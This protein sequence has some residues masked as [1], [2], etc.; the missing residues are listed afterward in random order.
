MPAQ[1]PQPGLAPRRGALCLLDGVVQQGRLLS[2][3]LPGALDRLP[4]DERARALRLAT[5]TLR[6]MDRADRLLGP[7][8]SRRPPA[9]GLNALRLGVVEMF[10]EGA[11]AH[12]VVNSLVAIMREKAQTRHLSGLVNAVL[13]KAAG[14]PAEAWENL[15]PPRLPRWLRKPL[16]AD[17]GKDAVAAIE[18]AHARDAPLD[19]SVK[20]PADA[21]A[22]A[23][24]LG[25]QVLPTGTVRLAAGRQVSALAGFDAGAW[26]V[27]DAAAALPVTLLD[28]QPGERV[29]DLCAAPGGKTMQIAASG[30][31]VTALDLSRSRSARPRENL[32]RTG[33]HARVLVADAL[34]YEAA[35]FDA[36]LLDAPCSATGTIRRHPDLPHAKNAGQFPALFALQARLLDRALGLLR[37][38]GRLVYCTCSLLIDEGEEQIRDLQARTPGVRLDPAAGSALPASWRVDTGLRT[39]PD[40]W[41]AR[42]GMDGFFMTRL[43]KLA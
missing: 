23:A 7:F 33:L 40:Y 17:Y 1:M 31:S 32:K 9:D 10:A 3:M 13:R 42:G 11:P 15:P 20:T 14:L 19:L 18:A 6:W 27:Q 5:T 30:A 35:P 4:P 22:W 12:G 29:L 36:I 2:A 26:W 43:Q 34:D 21:A 41:S 25:G 8:L 39:R 16:V 38:G 28:P 37:P 24:R